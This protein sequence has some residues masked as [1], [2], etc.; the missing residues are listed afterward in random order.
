[1]SNSTGDDRS[2]WTEHLVERWMCRVMAAPR[3][4]LGVLLGLVLMAGFAATWLRIDA[5]SSK[6][7]SPDLPAQARAHEL[8][9]A[10]PTLKSSIAILVD[11]PTADQADIA[12]Q[13]LVDALATDPEWVEMIF[14][15]VADPFFQAHG[16]LYRDLEGVEQAFSRI[17]R[18]ANLVATLREDQT[19]EG[20]ANA[21]YQAGE[22]AERAEISADALDRLYAEAAD[23]IKALDAGQP[24]IFGWSAVLD[25]AAD[26]GPVTRIVTVTPKLDLTRLSPAKPAL[27]EIAAVITALPEEVRQSVR[28]SVTGEP[29]LRAEEMQSVLG[30][31]GLSLGLS[32]VLV[33]AILWIGLRSGGR[34]LLAVGSLIVSLV[35]TTGFAAT[36]LGALNLVSV[37]FIVLLVG[38]GID[39]AIHILA[40]ITEM[41]QSGTPPDQSV[42]LTGRRSG[43]ALGLAAITTSLAFLAF[44]TTDFDG[45]AQLG[46]IGAVGVLI[47][48]GVAVTIIPAAV[49]L[50]PGL[51]GTRAEAPSTAPAPRTSGYVPAFAV[52]LLSAIAI[53][54][55]SQVRFD[56]NPMGLRNPDAPSVQAF[57]QLVRTPETSPYRASVLAM[58]AEE[59]AAIAKTFE[60][61]PGVGTAIHIGDLIPTEQDEKLTLLDITAPSIEHAVR[62]TPTELIA[63]VARDEAVAALVSRLEGQKGPARAL[64]NAL[65]GYAK[66]SDPARDAQLQARLFQAF[67]TMTSRLDAL[68]EADYVTAE[69]LPAPLLLRFVS[70]EWRYRVEVM[71]EADLSDPADLLAFADVV[72]SVDDRAAGGPVQLSAAGQTVGMAMLQATLLAALS[73]AILAFFATRHVRDTL[74]ILA[75]LVLAGIITA[76]ASVLLDMPFNYANVI[77]LP[78]LIGIGVDSGIHIA[79]RERR[80]PGAVFATS[81]PR[82]VLFSALTTMAAF[83]TLAL[84]DHRGTASMG[85]LLAVSMCASV[86]AVLA[87]TPALIR[88][89]RPNAHPM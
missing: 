52:I 68:L 34:A 41:R 37:A 58:S 42:A 59:A 88:L 55:A 25:D 62:G 83:G 23:V 26:P 73:T 30:T 71:P 89:G 32:L 54:P 51:A 36:A 10:F 67:P 82:A 31:L 57:D 78:L 24:R 43:L 75:P 50:A 40:H 22:L 27:Q 56:A 17:S 1:M 14:A 5:D 80:A 48:F 69:N 38:L 85:V 49:V 8:N 45:M 81:T 76:G 11:G 47:A 3:R 61:V 77:V 35:L 79:H 28:F 44:S 64:H 46:I 29:A 2:G 39:F 4:T 53:W 87:L 66:A 84:S 74:A 33:A 70:P 63:P 86:G 9:A 13:A 65:S 6:M 7:L 19:V 72:A 16:F 60:N 12:T 18:S 21:L 20:F 15:P